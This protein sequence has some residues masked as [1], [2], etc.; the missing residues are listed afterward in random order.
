[1]SGIDDIV[2]QMQAWQASMQRALAHPPYWTAPNCPMTDVAGN[3]YDWN[4]ICSP[5]YSLTGAIVDRTVGSENKVVG[6]GLLIAPNVVLTSARSVQRRDPSNLTLLRGLPYPIVRSVEDAVSPRS[7]VSYSDPA[8]LTKLAGQESSDIALLR[9]APA[10]GPDADRVWVNLGLSPDPLRVAYLR[11]NPDARGLGDAA[12]ADAVVVSYYQV[13]SKFLTPV[14]WVTVSENG[15]VLVGFNDH[16]PGDS[17]ARFGGVYSPAMDRGAPVIMVGSSL[18][19]PEVVGVVS[20][21]MAVEGKGTYYRITRCDRYAGWV[22]DS[23]AAWFGGT[24]PN[25]ITPDVSGATGV[26]L[27]RRR[28]SLLAAVLTLAAGAGIG[29]TLAR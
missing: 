19:R 9:L 3:P 27:V 29:L 13:G 1:M 10:A 26:P 8:D 4:L 24:A 20:G 5:A 15:S 11:R 17:N 25:P 14:K 2:E 28:G 22:A 16:Q 7:G 6:S 12:F 23:L 21:A 18:V